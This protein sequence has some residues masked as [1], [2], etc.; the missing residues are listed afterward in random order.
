MEFVGDMVLR[1]CLDDLVHRHVP[2]IGAKFVGALVRPV[3]VV[4]ITTGRERIV[5]RC[6]ALRTAGL[7][8]F[9]GD[10][11]HRLVRAAVVVRVIDVLLREE[12]GLLQVR[13]ELILLHARLA[14]QR[15]EV[16]DHAIA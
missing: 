3:F 12:A 5:A 13:G 8:Q 7:A 6:R 2:R 14:E 11:L 4:A 10:H 16:P 9:I 15:A 1:D